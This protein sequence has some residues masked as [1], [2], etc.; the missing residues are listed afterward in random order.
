M[1]CGGY[2]LAE[3]GWTKEA[4]PGWQCLRPREELPL[5]RYILRSPTRSPLFHEKMGR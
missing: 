3:P 5:A 1:G 4:R 2:R